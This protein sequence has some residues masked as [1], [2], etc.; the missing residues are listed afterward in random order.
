MST[1]SLRLLQ[2][3]FASKALEIAV[4]KPYS[5]SARHRINKPALCTVSV[6]HH[7]VSHTGHSM[8]RYSMGVGGPL[9]LTNSVGLMAASCLLSV[10][11]SFGLQQSLLEVVGTQRQHTPCLLVSLTACLRNLHTSNISLTWLPHQPHS[12]FVQPGLF[13]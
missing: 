9:R 1:A 5:W 11:I 3:L 13:T 6:N 10:E 2:V 12:V 8:A 7:V 4:C